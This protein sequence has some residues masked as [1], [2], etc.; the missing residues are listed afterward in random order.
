MKAQIATIARDAQAAQI[1]AAQET[2]DAREFVRAQVAELNAKVAAQ[3]IASAS[4]P[5][6]A[7]SVSDNGKKTS[8]NNSKDAHLSASFK[9]QVLGGLKAKKGE[10]SKAS[11][12]ACESV[13]S[14]SI[15]S[16][17]D[18]REE[19]EPKKKSDKDF[20]ENSD[21]DTTDHEPDPDDE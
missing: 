18:E 10:K 7:G 16:E 11:K 2:T 12:V 19:Q 17:G 21:D 9:S 15:D 13:Y 14:I 4:S 6:R 20:Y 5:V 3:E 1:A 8:V